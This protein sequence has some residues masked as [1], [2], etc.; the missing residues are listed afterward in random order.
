MPKLTRIN[1]PLASD[2]TEEDAPAYVEGYGRGAS[3][4]LE[5]CEKEVNKI[6]KEIFKETEKLL[7]PFWSPDIPEVLIHYKL[8]PERYQDL[9][10]RYLK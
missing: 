8:N 6:V 10:E 5:S 2:F 9:K 4:Q 3:A 1:I 7:M